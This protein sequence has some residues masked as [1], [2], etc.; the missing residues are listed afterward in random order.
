MNSHQ[1]NDHE[2]SRFKSIQVLVHGLLQ[3]MDSSVQKQDAAIRLYGVSAFASMLARKRGLQSELAAIAGVLHH[4]YF[5]KTGIEDFPGP[6]SSEAVRP[7]IRDLKLL[8]QEEQA[9]ILKAIYYHDDRHQRHGEYEEVVK[10]AIVLQKYFQTPNNQVD[11]RDS[12]RLQQV[13][14]E[15]TIPYS[16]ETPHNNTSTE[17][18]KTSNS[19][20]KR[21]MLADIAESLA[22]QNII[23]VPG[24]KFYREICKY[25]PDTNIY[26][27]I[28]ASWCAAFVYYCCRQAGISLPIRYPNG[29]Y[30]LAG[31]GAWLEWSQLPETGFFYRDGQEGFIPE[32]GDIVIYDKLLSDKAHDHIGVVLACEEKEIVVAEGKRDNQNYSSVFRRD[33]HH[34]ILGYIRIDNDYTFHFKG[35]LNSAYLG[36]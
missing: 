4:Y 3:S 12:H 28:R 29:I 36:E 31:V 19:T 10:D 21:Q 17:F 9:T 8:S 27:D 34:C 1:I 15:L 35:R 30:R 5:Y 22:G 24:D 32:R 7:M 20:D 33:R 18:P 26:Q 25:W 6:N 16:Y 23:G 11:S 14:G 13:L 2:V